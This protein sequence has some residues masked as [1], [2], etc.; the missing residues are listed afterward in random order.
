MKYFLIFIVIVAFLMVGYFA[1]SARTDT[2]TGRWMA[3]KSSDVDDYKRFPFE[4]IANAPPPHYFGTEDA[5]F[6]KIS[7]TYKGKIQTKNL[8]TLLEETG[9]TAFIV[10]NDGTIL[11]EN[12]FN[13]N[14]RDSI[15]TSFS[16][17]KSITALIVGIAIDDGY[18]ESLEDPVTKYMPELKNV[19]PRYAN[20]TLRHLLS[21]K[22][23]IRF[24]D[25]DIP[26][27]DKSR[28][29]YHPNLREVVTN[30]PIATAP[31]D[32]FVYNTFNPIILGMIVERATGQSVVEYFE[33]QFWQRMGM[34]YEASW[35]I[36]SEED[37]MAK[38]ES[39][40]NPRAI[41]F[42]K[43]GQ[44]LLSDGNWNGEQ[45]VPK[46][47]IADSKKIDPENRVSKIGENIYYQNG[48]WLYGPTETDK[49]TVSGWGHLGQYLFVFP[50]EN[51]L[52]MRFG[53]EIGKV[54]F[55][56]RDCPRN[57]Q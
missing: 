51:M 45:I 9:T 49:F 10:I 41:D 15:V 54:E 28:A 39:G 34:E 7:Y 6:K 2:F 35:S 14:Q 18:I 47:W 42:A 26:W 16:I 13:G 22:S 30:L 53:K 12:Y 8:D 11:Y 37:A 33:A 23:G 55:L 50:D 3:W 32:E 27:H 31:G 38:M 57:Y 19:D 29:Y 17:A 43:I 1:L 21:M 20:I 56:A 24:K 52:V 4:I 5:S 44:L 40:I 36:D 48:W 46:K 25:T